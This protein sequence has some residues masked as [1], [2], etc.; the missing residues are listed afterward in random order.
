MNRERDQHISRIGL[1]RNLDVII[2]GAF[3]RLEDA[4]SLGV[5]YWGNFEI[6]INDEVAM[7]SSYRAYGRDEGLLPTRS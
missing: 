6:P 4:F 5:I 7:A 2:F 3:D 1:Q